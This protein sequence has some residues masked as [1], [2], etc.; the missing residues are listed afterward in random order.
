MRADAIIASQHRQL[1]YWKSLAS[2]REQAC[3]Q[4]QGVNDEKDGTIDALS[5]VCLLPSADS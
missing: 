5:K 1:E 4:D 3:K 2:E